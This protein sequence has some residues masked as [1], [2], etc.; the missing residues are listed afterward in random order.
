MAQSLN[1]HCIEDGIG[2][3]RPTTFAFDKRRIR[4]RVPWETFVE[5]AKARGI[6]STATQLR[7]GYDDVPMDAPA[8]QYEECLTCVR[9]E[10][11][12]R[13]A[14]LHAINTSQRHPWTRRLS[15]APDNAPAQGSMEMSG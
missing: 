4:R 12:A 13:N 5:Q 7:R 11:D 10:L 2:F 9:A 3:D 15:T 8:K 14:R 6:P 1:D